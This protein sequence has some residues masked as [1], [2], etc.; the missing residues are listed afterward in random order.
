VT[1]STAASV[2]DL[3]IVAA[4]MDE[5]RRAAGRVLVAVVRG[6]WDDLGASTDKYVRV[7]AWQFW[8]GD[9]GDT[10]VDRMRAAGFPV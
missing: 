5:Q 7:S 1:T 6:L 4:L 10:F 9:D 2:R 3:E 8:D